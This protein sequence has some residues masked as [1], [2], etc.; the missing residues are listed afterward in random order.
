[1]QPYVLMIQADEDDQYLTESILAE[2]QDTV[3][4]HFA[5][6]VD[7]ISS[8]VG[9]HGLPAVVLINNQDHRHA[10]LELINRL[11]KDDEFNSIPLV[12]LGEITTSAYIRQYYRA[13]ASSYIVK[14]STIAGMKKKIRLFLDYWFEVAEVQQNHEKTI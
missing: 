14:P 3:P 7:E 5:G 4:M 9:E 2:W 10:A 8:I 11:K 1:M 12:V 13:G 6:R